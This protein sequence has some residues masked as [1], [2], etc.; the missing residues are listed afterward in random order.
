MY[1]MEDVEACEREKKCRKRIMVSQRPAKVV[2]VSLLV[3]KVMP[4]SRSSQSQHIIIIRS[5]WNGAMLGDLG[6]WERS[7]AVAKRGAR[8]NN[9]NPPCLFWPH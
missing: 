8:C 9:I 7:C 6:N 1:V 3:M 4:R 5:D 2:S